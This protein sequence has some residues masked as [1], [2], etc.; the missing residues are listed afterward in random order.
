MDE[1]ELD[2]WQH[3]QLIWALRWVAADPEAAIAAAGTN[4]VIADEI[5]LGLDAVIQTGRATRRLAPSIRAAIGEIDAIFGQMS[6]R[7]HAQFWTAE[8]IRSDSRWAQQRERA[9]RVLK[10]L[11]ERRADGELP[12]HV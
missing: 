1:D 5:A 12:G 3:E 11:G 2:R 10:Q 4:V 6:R 8:A 9:R 7:E